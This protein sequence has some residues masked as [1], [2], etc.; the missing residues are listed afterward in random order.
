MAKAQAI[1]VEYVEDRWAALA[2]GDMVEVLD[3]PSCSSV[4]LA[5]RH[6]DALLEWHGDWL[7]VFDLGVWS[8]AEADEPKRFCAVVS[9]RQGEQRRYGVLRSLS[10]PR[11]VEVDDEAAAPLPDPRWRGFARACFRSGE[12]A[13]PVLALRELFETADAGKGEQDGEN[14]SGTLEYNFAQACTP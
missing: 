12:Q 13:V 3:Q 2:F 4:P 7:P 5:P 10:F 6:C 11:I 8:G 1:L 14:R 9:Y